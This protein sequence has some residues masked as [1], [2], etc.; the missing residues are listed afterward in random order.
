MAGR[1][2]VFNLQPGDLLSHGTWF[3][4][5]LACLMVLALIRDT[6]IKSLRRRFFFP[7]KKKK[8]KCFENIS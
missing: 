7:L 1:T 6:L 3:P 4:R 8:S 5:N 2:E